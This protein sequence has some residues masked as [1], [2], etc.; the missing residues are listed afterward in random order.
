MKYSNIKKL[1][2]VEILG[3]MFDVKWDK[4]ES[5]GHAYTGDNEIMI[6]CKYKRYVFSILLHEISEVCHILLHQ[7]YADRSVSENFK[8]LMDHKEF[9]IHCDLVA[10]TIQKFMR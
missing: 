10:Q 8:I 2:K 3:L 1:K 9:E 4:N 7:H 6:G 5:G